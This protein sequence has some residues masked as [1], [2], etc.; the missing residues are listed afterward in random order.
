LRTVFLCASRSRD[1]LISIKKIVSL[2]RNFRARKLRSIKAGSP[3]R[4]QF[5]VT[6]LE[7]ITSRTT[8]AA[9]ME[10]FT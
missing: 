5:A 9:M 10:T 1:S 7:G 3:R 8:M 4:L 6:P 2:E